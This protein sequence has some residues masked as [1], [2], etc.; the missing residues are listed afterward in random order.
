MKIDLPFNKPNKVAVLAGYKNCTTRKSP[1]GMAGDKF[2][3]DGRTYE[4]T[5]V[6]PMTLGNVAGCLHENEGYESAIEF[7]QAFMSIYHKEEWYASSVVYVHWFRE[8]TA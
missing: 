2:T 3:V 4:L 5:M 8:V 1:K 7:T 6:H